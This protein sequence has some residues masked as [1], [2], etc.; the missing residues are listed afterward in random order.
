MDLI[1]QMRRAVRD[2]DQRAEAE[3]NLSTWLPSYAAAQKHYGDYASEKMSSGADLITEV[4]MLLACLRGYPPT[5]AEAI[6][7]FYC[8][9]DEL[10]YPVEPGEADPE[11]ADL[12]ADVR[13][14]LTR[15]TDDEVCAFLD[16]WFAAQGWT[17]RKKTP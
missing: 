10:L 12:D 3:H 2:A 16:E 14:R 6:E 7:W 5:K 17:W 13:A 9:R 1:E 15:P 8:D 11:G 4:T